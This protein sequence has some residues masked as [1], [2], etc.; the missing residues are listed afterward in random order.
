[1]TRSVHKCPVC[2]EPL[3]VKKPAD[4][5]ILYCGNGPCSSKAANQ[6]AI[7]GTEADAFEA[8]KR[9]INDEANRA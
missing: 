2:G 9:F 8:L 7:S 4:F 6:G 1:M 5:V 3:S